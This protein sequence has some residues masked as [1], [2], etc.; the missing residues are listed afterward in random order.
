MKSSP[1]YT[2][3]SSSNAL[4]T[5]GSG[6]QAST[7]GVPPRNSGIP[8]YK[9]NIERQ[10]REQKSV[11]GILS[12]IV[13]CTV[14]L[15]LIG[16]GLA[17]YGLYVLKEQVS[18]QAVTISDLQRKFDAKTTEL[19]NRLLSTQETLNQA[20]AQMNR[21]NEV[22]VQ[23]GEQINKLIKVGEDQA[24]ALASVNSSLNTTAAA[25]ARERSGR[26]YSTEEIKEKMR[27]LENRVE[28]LHEQ[29]ASLSN[30]LK[31]KGLVG[32]QAPRKQ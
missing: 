11:G 17:F 31:P 25:L 15:L 7:G 20:L 3:S 13:Y 30:L 24:A 28:E 18:G 8:D 22:I 19:Q 2:T 1:P 14:A 32:P 12:I 4:K 21:E 10:A 9:S 29:E 6:G 16:G 23:Q 5:V 27:H 26:V